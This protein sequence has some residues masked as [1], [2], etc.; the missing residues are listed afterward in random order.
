MVL[1]SRLLVLNW[2]WRVICSCAVADVLSLEVIRLAC[3]TYAWARV[4][5]ER[6]YR[7]MG[8]IRRP[9]V[10]EGVGCISSVGGRFAGSG[11]LYGCALF[12]RLFEDS[13]D[14]MEWTGYIERRWE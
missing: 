9:G 8:T 2:C 11:G 5:V 13:I 4:D 6:A 12:S 1:G 7:L 3:C 10:A 14:V